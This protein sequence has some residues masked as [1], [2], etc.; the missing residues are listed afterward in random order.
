MHGRRQITNAGQ[1]RIQR[2]F[3]YLKVAV[4]G[5]G[6]GQNPRWRDPAVWRKFQLETARA[7]LPPLSGDQA[8]CLL[9]AVQRDRVGYSSLSCGAPS[10]S[11]GTP[12]S[13]F[14]SRIARADLTWLTLGAA[15]SC[16]VR[17]RL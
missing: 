7:A 17:N 11:I 13:C 14:D 6:E 10:T 8:D 12:K 16:E 5:T 2:Y 4:P 1:R 15:V 3:Q 9:N